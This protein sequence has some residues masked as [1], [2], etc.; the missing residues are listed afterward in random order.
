MK[1]I[2]QLSVSTVFLVA[3]ITMTGCKK[4]SNGENEADKK[5]LLTS[6]IW[7]LNDLSTTSTDSNVQLAVN[8]MKV[9]MGNAT[10]NYTTRGTYTISLLGVSDSGSWEFNA[11]ETS[12]IMD[13]GTADE[14]EE[15][16]VKLTSDVLELK[17]NVQ[18][19]DL[20]NFSITYKW[21]K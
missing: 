18:D 3:L 19:V 6:H 2:L 12:I 7:K 16:I 8:L 14:S 1:N 17:E 5:V 11:G 10:L 21:I 20:G 13:K 15:I 9:L 4:D